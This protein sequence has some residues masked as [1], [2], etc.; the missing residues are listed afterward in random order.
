MAREAGVDL[1][2][3]AEH[4][5]S[6]LRTKQANS[7]ELASLR[8]SPMNSDVVRRQLEKDGASRKPR[9]KDPDNLSSDAAEKW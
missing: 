8:I 3:L 2:A 1:D 7:V 9:R 5:R 6:E 4:F